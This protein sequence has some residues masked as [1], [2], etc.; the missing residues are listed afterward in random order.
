MQFGTYEWIEVETFIAPPGPYN[1]AI[2]VR[3]VQGEKY[4][5][6]TVVECSRSL[7]KSYPVGTRFLLQCKLTNR[8]GG[9]PFLYSHY[10]SPFKVIS[11][12]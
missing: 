9:K 11:A 12:P 6:D 10:N 5:P 7:R 3:P 1:S 2:R 4:P 8:E